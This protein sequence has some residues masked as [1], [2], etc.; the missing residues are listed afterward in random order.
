MMVRRHVAG[1]Y[2]GDV[3]MDHDYDRGTL[4]CIIS[5]RVQLHQFIVV[6][7]KLKLVWEGHFAAEGWK[8][9]SGQPLTEGKTMEYGD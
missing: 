3:E 5:C 7:L 4:P 8:H 6:G 9:V 2:A 1:Q